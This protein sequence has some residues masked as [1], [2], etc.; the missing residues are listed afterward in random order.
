MVLAVKRLM[1]KPGRPHQDNRQKTLDAVKR[2]R[3]ADE[4][5]KKAAA[6]HGLEI[7]ELVC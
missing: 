1:I 6:E 4:A 7:P 3:E 5:V 2:W